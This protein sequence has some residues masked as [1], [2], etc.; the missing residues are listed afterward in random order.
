MA[1]I[2]INNPFDNL[3]EEGAKPQRFILLAKELAARGNS[4]TL[5]TSSFSHAKKKFRVS[6]DGT[7]L[8]DVYKNTDGVTIRLIPTLPYKSNISISRIFSHTNYGR[9]WGEIAFSEVAARKIAPPE[10]VI[11]STPPIS[12]HKPALQFK[13]AWDSKIVLDI[14]DLWPEAFRQLLPKRLPLKEAFY[15]ILFGRLKRA[16]KQAYTKSDKITAVSDYYLNVAKKDGNTSPSKSFPHTCL[17]V[18]EAPTETP[19]P[20]LRLVYIGNMGKFYDLKTVINGVIALS[21]KNNKQ[22]SISL[23]IAGSGPDENTLRSLAAGHPEIRFHGF[24][25]NDSLLSLLKN[26]DAGIIPIFP[27]SMVQIPY[28]LPDYASSGL[29]IITS[30]KGETLKLVTEEQCGIYYDALDLNAFMKS[31]QRLLEDKTLL[32]SMKEA[33]LKLAKK[34]FLA[35]KVYSDFADFILDKEKQ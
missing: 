34:H 4:V 21:R 3:P 18:A 5:W 28:K 13:R 10:I 8:P 19:Q 31:V 16:A 12:N 27:D 14:M 24:L 2:W 22:R 9:T 6:A 15:A 32:V 1:E 30:L 29:A 35:Q 25:D 33:A 23:D 7:P 26:S 11:I 17:S 20:T